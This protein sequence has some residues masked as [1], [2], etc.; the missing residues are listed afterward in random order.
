MRCELA[1]FVSQLRTEADLLESADEFEQCLR[2]WELEAVTSKHAEKSLQAVAW[3]V[4]RVD[5][6]LM[7]KIEAL[8][9]LFDLPRGP[10]V[11]GM[12][13]LTGWW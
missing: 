4:G 7:E 9:K 8:G 10:V 3:I 12:R 2:A 1:G 5:R 6:T 13:K 11:V